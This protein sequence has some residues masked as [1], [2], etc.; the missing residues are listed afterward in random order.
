[1][2][3]PAKSLG[4]FKLAP[5]LMLHIFS[6]LIWPKFR[7]GSAHSH[8]PWQLAHVCQRWRAILFGPGKFFFA[9]IC[10]QDNCSYRLLCTLKAEVTERVS[11]SRP[12]GLHIQFS[13][14]IGLPKIK[15]EILL[16]LATEAERWESLDICLT[17]N[18]IEAL[19]IACGRFLKLTRL[20]LHI[21]KILPH[22]PNYSYRPLTAF[23][24]C[25]RLTSF[26]FNCAPSIDFARVSLPYPKVQS[27]VLENDISSLADA[28][29]KCPELQH[30]S[31]SPRLIEGV[32]RVTVQVHHNKLQC[33]AIPLASFLQNVTLPNLK[34]LVI[35]GQCNDS[36][37]FISAF[38]ARSRANL[39]ELSLPNFDL[40]HKL[41]LE[42]LECLPSVPLI[43]LGDMDFFRSKVRWRDGGNRGASC[44]IR[45]QSP[46]QDFILHGTLEDGDRV[47][48]FFTRLDGSTS[49]VQGITIY[50]E[51]EISSAINVIHET[52]RRSISI[53]VMGKDGG[54][55]ESLQF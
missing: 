44:G 49:R 9:E 54:I 21:K 43:R 16:A 34:V 7:S 27:L 1:M 53:C 11:I 20:R 45:L 19:E 40:Q 22:V 55:W 31:M 12:F 52:L 5:E 42:L 51:G 33:L 48:A 37:T 17:S 2:S 25:P 36:N 26:F 24:N 15:K 6:F 29:N 3:L 47:R 18:G 32:K 28:L 8:I 38:L 13:H 23:Q 50:Y 10:V 4:L 46:P 14:R 35:G 41:D 30:L 39:W